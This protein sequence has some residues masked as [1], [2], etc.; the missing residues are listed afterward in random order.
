MQ[1]KSWKNYSMPA[2][3]AYSTN[4]NLITCGAAISF[5][6]IDTAMHAVD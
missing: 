4:E 1:V 2:N 3:N 5:V 6:M